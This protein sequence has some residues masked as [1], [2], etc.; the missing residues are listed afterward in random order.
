MRR[1][2]LI[3]YLILILVTL[4]AAVGVFWL[5]GY[6]FIE[7]Q[8]AVQYE[9]QAR[10]L[11]EIF[12]VQEKYEHMDYQE[13][14][15]AYGGEYGVR[16]TLIQQDGT[17]AA[18]SE[19]L[20][21]LENHD[22]REEVQEALKGVTASA[23]RYSE[24]MRAQTFYTAVPVHTPD[25][26]GVLRVSVPMAELNSLTAELLR[27]VL[28]A[29][30][31]I[32]IMAL[33]MADCFSRY[34]IRPLDEVTK[35]A[36]EIAG[37][38]YGG[39]IHT[40]QNGEIGR[41][42]YT[43]NEMSQ[44]LR[45]HVDR[46]ERRNRELEAML[47]SMDSAVA[48]IDDLNT[49]LFYNDGLVKLTGTG[50]RNLTG[51]ALYSVIRNSLVF[52]VVD[53]VR[54]RG[55]SFVQE[56]RINNGQERYIRVMGT[57]LHELED[58]NLGVL[59]ILED[60]TEIKK[61]ENMRSDFVSN[62]THEL[63]T[64]LTSIRGF[65][66]T[67]KNGAIHNEKIAMKFLDIIDI[68]SERL[69]HLIQ[70]ILLLSEIES[71][72]DYQIEFCEV[73]QVIGEVIE[74]LEPKKSEHTQLV[75]HPQAY[76]KPYPCNRNRI[77]Q[78]LINLVDNA[79]KNTEVGQVQISCYSSDKELHLEVS[80]TGIGIKEDAL[81]RIFERFYRIDKGRSRKQGG[82]GLGLSI[83]K[84][85]VEMYNGNIQVVSRPNEGTIFTV[86]LPY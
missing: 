61:L 71:K 28:A 62:V 14:A 59:L 66:D 81:P 70:D 23:R 58:K 8:S 37:G 27:T 2:I 17:V 15:D 53:G 79:I 48:A 22:N 80:D 77:K 41:L 60:I 63:K 72:K 36:E 49:I 82:T 85:I 26:Q 10:M 16:I 5:K 34:L 20:G 76:V 4:T 18:D 50:T 42:A 86:T 46:L 9:S 75:Y 68:E 30:V 13:F 35:A 64:P 84:H 43:F 65:V 21:S 69:Y 44:T 29:L 55:D 31:F 56:G 74:L 52:D 6:H 12:S 11:A 78:L 3:T 1:K 51:Q 73:N 54:K 38:N 83:V 45:I 32:C 67:L 7:D 19:A 39:K 33:L 25:F 24:T 40:Q 47:C 57:P